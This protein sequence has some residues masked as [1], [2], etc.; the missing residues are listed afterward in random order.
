MLSNE[1]P[2]LMDLMLKEDPIMERLIRE[3]ETTL[4]MIWKDNLMA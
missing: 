3:G 1:S 4:M 2:L